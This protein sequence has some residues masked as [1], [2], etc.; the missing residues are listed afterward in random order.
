MQNLWRS[1]SVFPAWTGWCWIFPKIWLYMFISSS[2][3]NDDAGHAFSLV[4]LSFFN[5]SV[6]SG[7]DAEIFPFI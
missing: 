4:S 5:F 6:S 1:T 2:T 3:E 7:T